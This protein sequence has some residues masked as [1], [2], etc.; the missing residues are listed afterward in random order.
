[1]PI[2]LQTFAPVAPDAA[3]SQQSVYGMLG[4][5]DPKV[6]RLFM[7]SGIDRRHLFIE[8]SFRAGETPTQ[9]YQRYKSGAVS[10]GV[11]AIRQAVANTGTEDI[12]LLVTVSCTGYLCPG[13]SAYL[14]DALNLPPSIQRCDIL[15]LGCAGAVPGLARAVDYV[16]AHPGKRALML[17]VEI[18]SAAYYVDDSVETAIGNAICGDGACA[19]LVGG[20]NPSGKASWRVKEI[21]SQVQTEYLPLVGFDF[22]EG[23]LK[24]ILAREIQELAGPLVKSVVH[25]FL[26]RKGLKMVDIRHWII[27]PG[28]R[29]VIDHIQKALELRDA[30]VQCSRDILREYGNMS[31]VTVL[32]VADHVMRTHPDI[33]RGDLALMLAMGPGLA[34][35]GALLQW[36]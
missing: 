27:H 24:I 5:D 15:G 17:A 12:G 10:L 36:D 8:S 23:F 31:S 13:L 4:Y 16:T 34:V 20:E 35:E 19:V 30:Q 33:R 7:N 1:M 3:F 6:L 28:G 14:I 22:K 32:F 18:C 26:E 25:G 11:Q 2:S 29:K 21:F 9:L